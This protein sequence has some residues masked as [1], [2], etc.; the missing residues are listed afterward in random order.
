MIKVT[1]Q[2]AGKK[3]GITNGYQFAKSIGY[4]K[5]VGIR[6]WNGEQEPRLRTL[7][8]ICK[9]WKCDLAEL[10]KYVA[11]RNGRKV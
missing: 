3:R 10:V 5:S 6:I 4:T 9:A 8:T 7:D 1:I 11:E 2:A